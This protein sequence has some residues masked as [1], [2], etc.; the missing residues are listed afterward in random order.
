MSAVYF[1]LGVMN[2]ACA[3]E[4]IQ[5]TATTSLTFLC[6]DTSIQSYTQMQLA[7]ALR[8]AKAV[9]KRGPG[10]SID[11]D[12]D[13]DGVTPPAR[14]IEALKENLALAICKAPVRDP[15]AIPIYYIAS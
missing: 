8:T 10:C 4:N 15:S 14:S 11:V 1:N 5:L 6:G 3:G 2:L 13:C 9:A 7:R 12:V